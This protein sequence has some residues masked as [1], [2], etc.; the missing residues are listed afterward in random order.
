MSGEGVQHAYHETASAAQSSPFR[1]IPIACV[2]DDQCGIAK[3]CQEIGYQ[4]RAR[5]PRSINYLKSSATKAIRGSEF[6]WVWLSMPIKGRHIP[7]SKYSASLEEV[8]KM[9][10]ACEASSTPCLLFGAFGNP[11][12]HPTIHQI[13]CC[14]T[15]TKKYHRLCHYGLS[16][17]GSIATA[18]SACLISLS[19]GLH[20]ANHSCKCPEDT[21]HSMD[22]LTPG[23][24]QKRDEVVQIIAL[25]LFSEALGEGMG[26]MATTQRLPDLKRLADA[27]DPTPETVEPNLEQTA[28]PTEE[29]ML[30]KKKEKERKDRGDPSTRG[31][32]KQFVEDHH[33]DCGCDL[34]GLGDDVELETTSM[35][36]N[37][38]PLFTQHSANAQI[39]DDLDDA[40][41]Y[42]ARKPPGLDIV[43]LCGG[44]ARC[45]QIAMRRGLSAGDN[46]DLKCNCDL[47]DSVNQDKVLEYIKSVK[48]LVAVMAPTCT[49]Y[50]PMAN[51]VKHVTPASWKRSLDLARP[52]GRFCGRVAQLIQSIG[53]YFIAAQPHPSNLWR[54][55]EW[56]AVQRHPCTIK[57]VIHQCMA[58]QTGPSGMPA[59]KPTSLMANHVKL[60]EPLT[61]FVCDHSHTH[62]PL[63]GGKAVYCQVWPWRMAQ[64]IVDGIVGLKLE[65]EAQGFFPE[66]GSG[67]ADSGEVRPTME[68]PAC[69]HHMSRYDARHTRDHRCRW[70]D[71]EPITWD[72]E[73]CK[74]DR[75]AGHSSHTYGPDCK[76]T[77]ISHRR[78]T[79][80]SG[81]HPRQPATH[82]SD[83]PAKEAQ[84]Q[85]PDG[86]DL[87]PEAP[88]GESEEHEEAGVGSSDPPPRPIVADSPPEADDDQPE[89]KERRARKKEELPRK[90]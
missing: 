27:S 17:D 61:K 87:V 68:R 39:F 57:L 88:I 8:V 22:W 71:E 81:R 9:L 30:Q 31:T 10:I 37:G 63:E 15:W 48:P 53:K 42:M 84:A 11:W 14:P 16:I 49:P 74:G 45:T 21:A 13:S 73:A 32:R 58:G 5:D 12:N 90:T 35:F 60:L 89:V 56:L 72:C 54:E 44:E 18:S 29:R 82:A 55:P 34:S 26:D 67:T 64:A 62:E 80:R 76:H 75:P 50:G 79:P 28:F 33:D 70:R 2:I 19:H 1:D 20:V 36:L 6:A 86:S 40:I 41:A 52:H 38:L 85:L 23:C 46:F 66:L 59:K 24:H 77:I 3:V 83:M 78:G 4:V 65:M 7:A 51:L 43:E 69:R 47:N 25:H